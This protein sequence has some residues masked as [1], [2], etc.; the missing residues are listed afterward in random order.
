[1]PSFFDCLIFSPYPTCDT[2]TSVL[3]VLVEN[4]YHLG[5][6]DCVRGCYHRYAIDRRSVSKYCTIRRCWLWSLA[7]LTCGGLAFRIIAGLD[8]M[9][10]LTWS[11]VISVVDPFYCPFGSESGR[12][13]LRYVVSAQ[14]S[15][16]DAALYRS[17]LFAASAHR[18][19]SSG[20]DLSRT[21]L[22]HKGE[23]IR[24]INASLD[25]SPD[26][27]SDFTVAAIG[28]LAV[29]QVRC[30]CAKHCQLCGH[31]SLLNITE[32]YKRQERTIC[33]LECGRD[34]REIT[35]GC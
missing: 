34:P 12:N 22:M 27:V 6:K 19:F 5:Q 33:A 16:A 11:T 8:I 14:Q 30:T 18:D 2:I 15:L 10:W 32:P 26:D 3:V 7:F 25:R 24:L 23:T 9:C 21:T 29:T 28:M 31:W 4:H 1:M 17:I 13:N 35:R 20:N